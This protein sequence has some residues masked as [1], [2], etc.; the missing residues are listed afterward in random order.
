[1]G[2]KD[3]DALAKTIKRKLQY[4]KSLNHLHTF[5]VRQKRRHH[6]KENLTKT[7]FQQGM[8]ESDST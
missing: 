2:I 1:M 8:L 6:R 4:K 3:L 5:E 7:H